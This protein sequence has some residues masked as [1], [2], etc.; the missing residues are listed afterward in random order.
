[1]KNYRDSDYAINKYSNSIVY[2][3]A[4]R[5]VEVTLS[6]YLAEN[7]QKT[8]QDFIELKM[9]SDE[10]YL[11]QV[12]NENAQTK[13]NVS[14]D[15]L[16]ETEKCATFPLDEQYM[17]KQNRKYVIQA[18]RK[19]LEYDLLTDIQKRRFILFYFKGLT[20]RRIAQLE[21]ITQNAVWK[22]INASEKKLKKLFDDGWSTSR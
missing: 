22:S 10:I 2:R 14:L 19:L 1:M 13:K 3:F 8:E 6:D 21:G 18:A 7:S 11:E 15:G 9:L 20:T 5:I 12:R 17:E 16:D 4:D